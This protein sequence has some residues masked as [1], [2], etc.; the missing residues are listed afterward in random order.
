MLNHPVISYVVRQ[1]TKFHLFIFRALDVLDSLEGIS[2]A[3]LS[4]TGA[5]R[6]VNGLKKHEERRIFLKL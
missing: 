4:E 3:V 5:G 2:I 1:P 6:A